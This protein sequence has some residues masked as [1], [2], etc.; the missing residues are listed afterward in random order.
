MLRDGELTGRQRSGQVIR[1]PSNGGG[2]G[3]S[4]QFDRLFRVPEWR[5]SRRLLR[6][7]HDA[8]IDPTIRAQALSRPT[9][10]VGASFT[11]R[12]TG[13]PSWVLLTGLVGGL[14]RMGKLEARLLLRGY[15]LVTIDVYRL[16]IDSADVSF[17]TLAQRVDALLADANI[18]H[19]HVVGHAHGGGVALRLAASYPARVSA[20]DL[21]DVGALPASGTKAPCVRIVVACPV[22]RHRYSEQ[23]QWGT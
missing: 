9:L 23:Q 16:S 2:D 19:A 17:A 22:H 11:R 13:S 20:V 6:S 5:Q 8:S 7:P 1:C 14:E 10:V 18:G 12:G 21:L 4:D 15:R 3:G